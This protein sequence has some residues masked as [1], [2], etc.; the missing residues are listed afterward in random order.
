MRPGW[1]AV[2]IG[3]EVTVLAAFT[4]VGIHLFMQPHRP[5]LSP[6]PLTLP[7]TSLPPLPTSATPAPVQRQKPSIH[8]SASPLSPGWFPRF[9]DDDRRLM[10]AQWEA[11][12]RLMQAVEHYLE[13]KVIPQM[14]RK[15]D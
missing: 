13:R 15:H 7:V 9:G 11:L 12:Q 3:S 10:N 2:V 8:P 14:Q 4:G 1:K 5:G 6:P